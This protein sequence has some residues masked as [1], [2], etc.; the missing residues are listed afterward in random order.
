[1]RTFENRSCVLILIERM[2]GFGIHSVSGVVR[3]TYKH[4]VLS[5][6]LEKVLH[7]DFIGSR[8]ALS[9]A[10]RNLEEVRVDSSRGE[11][12]LTLN[13]GRYSQGAKVR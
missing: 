13:A 8:S 9:L 1:M 6:Y 4:P 12:L 7:Q 3:D 5:S 2:F 11:A 10:C